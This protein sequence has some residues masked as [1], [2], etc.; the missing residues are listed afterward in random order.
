MLPDICHQLA[1]TQK[2]AKSGIQKNFSKFLE[3]YEEYECVWDVRHTDYGKRNKRDMAIEYASRS[4]DQVTVHHINDCQQ[5]FRQKKNLRHWRPEIWSVRVMQGYPLLP[6]NAR[7]FQVLFLLWL[8]SSSV[9]SLY[10]R[11]HQTQQFLKLMHIHAHA[12]FICIG[13]SMASSVSSVLE[14]PNL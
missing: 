2:C 11:L 6:H 10:I 12:S 4:F 7:L 3:R 5:Y 1:R 8:R 9:C 13:S 14:P